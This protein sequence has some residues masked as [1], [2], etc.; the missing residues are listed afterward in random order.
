MKWNPT[1]FAVVFFGLLLAS[2]SKKISDP[3]TPPVDDTT[4][5][6]PPPPAPFNINSINDT[7]GNLAGAANYTRWGVY[8]VHTHLLSKMATG[9]IATAPM[10]PME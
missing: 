3:V 9:I 4:T 5:T 1:Y 7:Y 10:P 6:T 8:N 2:C